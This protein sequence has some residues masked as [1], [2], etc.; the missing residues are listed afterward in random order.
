MTTLPADV[1]N[2]AREAVASA[3]EANGGYTASLVD[4]IRQGVR[5]HI[6][7]IQIAARV[8]QAERQRFVADF[9]G[10]ADA[11]IDAAVAAERARCV[12]IVR[13]FR[14]VGGEPGMR[15]VRPATLDEI[16]AMIESS[17]QP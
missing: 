13:L 8:I 3:F 5:D 12:K 16:A 9:D 2:A 11:G 1:M 15:T 4:E 17:A 7:V 10:A 14:I 6:L